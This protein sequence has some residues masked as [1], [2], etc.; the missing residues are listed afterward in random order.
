[1]R[2]VFDCGVFLQGLISETGPAVKCLEL[3]EQGSFT[4]VFSEETLD[5]LK[6]VLSRSRLREKYPRL[7]DESVDALVDVL[8][9]KA[10]FVKKVP[11]RFTY[12]RPRRRALHKSCHRRRCKIYRKP[13]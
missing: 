2:V 1:M 5:E 13:R 3:F 12:T 9:A 6:D 7:T 4:L 10:E 11:S 8:W